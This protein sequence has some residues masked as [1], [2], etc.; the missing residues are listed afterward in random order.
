MNASVWRLW[1]KITAIGHRMLVACVGGRHTHILVELPET[2][3][4][5]RREIGRAKQAAS[6]A[7]RDAM[8]GRIWA[9]GGDFR[10]IQDHDHARRTFK[11][12]LDHAEEGAWVWSYKDAERELS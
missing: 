1:K 4:E 12:I 11:Y 6:H 10:Q 9:D 8:P 3:S 2:L 7:V 5:A